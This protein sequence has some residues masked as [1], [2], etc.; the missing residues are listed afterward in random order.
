[1]GPSLSDLKDLK[2]TFTELIVDGKRAVALMR[3]TAHAAHGP[4]TQDP[5]IFVITV[6]GEKIVD[7]LEMVDTVMIETQCFGK[8]LSA[9]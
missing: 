1:M 3:A 5:A 7:L 4:Y 2:S 9:A 6:E 8:K